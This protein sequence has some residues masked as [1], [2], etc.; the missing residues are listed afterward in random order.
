MGTVGAHHLL[1]RPDEGLAILLVGPDYGGM[2]QMAELA[3]IEARDAGRLQTADARMLRTG[4]MISGRSLVLIGSTVEVEG[5]LDRSAFGPWLTSLA[6]AVDRVVYA[7]SDTAVMVHPQAP[8]A[9]TEVRHGL[10]THHRAPDAMA[11]PELV[12]A[13]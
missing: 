13:P 7:G 6:Y 8:G 4:V 3:G 10:V 2:R 5:L 11:L 1:G 9:W 12:T